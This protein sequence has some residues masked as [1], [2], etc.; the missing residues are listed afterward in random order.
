M[1]NEE[2]YTKEEVEAYGQE[3]IRQHAQEKSNVHSFFTRV[4]QHED[5]TRV[6]NVKEEELGEPQLTIRGLKELE[7]FSRDIEESNLWANYFKKMADITTATSL[8]KEGFLL[9]LSVTNKKE[10]ADVTPTR[11]KN[12]GWFKKGNKRQE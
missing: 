9:R 5:T 4:I 7:I 12:K 2:L 6:G 8:S 1:S 10:V 11:K 3:L